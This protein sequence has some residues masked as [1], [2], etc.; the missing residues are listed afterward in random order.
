MNMHEFA[1]NVFRNF[2]QDPITDRWDLDKIHAS[3]TWLTE[4]YHYVPFG[5]CRMPPDYDFKRAGCGQYIYPALKCAM[6]S[7]LEPDTAPFPLLPS[8][9]VKSVEFLMAI[10]ARH[11][12]DSARCKSLQQRTFFF[13]LQGLTIAGDLLDQTALLQLEAVSMAMVGRHPTDRC[14]ILRHFLKWQDQESGETFLDELSEVLEPPNHDTDGWKI[15][16]LATD[17]SQKVIER[18]HS[19]GPEMVG[20]KLTIPGYAPPHASVQEV[21]KQCFPD[22]DFLTEEYSTKARKGT[23]GVRQSFKFAQDEAVYDASTRRTVLS[24]SGLPWHYSYNAEKDKILK[25]RPDIPSVELFS[26]SS[27]VNV[28]IRSR[29]NKSAQE[30]AKQRPR[31]RKIIDVGSTFDPLPKKGKTLTS[32]ESL[33]RKCEFMK[34]AW[35]LTHPGRLEAQVPEAFKETVEWLGGKSVIQIEVARGEAMTHIKDTVQKWS[36]THDEHVKGMPAQSQKF[37]GKCNSFAF[38]MLLRE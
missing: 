16:N 8:L 30:A 38:E 33:K 29:V 36:T 24:E 17:Y 22:M 10:S 2:G 28:E 18:A 7:P 21:V 19:L 13:I 35:S 32:N 20:G 4:A 14:I 15:F 11:A 37:F 5:L 9:R 26:V 23:R 12:R 3:V 25:F 1:E 31:K 6:C 34:H 27:A